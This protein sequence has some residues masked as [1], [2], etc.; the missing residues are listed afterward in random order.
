[1]VLGEKT[2]HRVSVFRCWYKDNGLKITFA[3]ASFEINQFL[4]WLNQILFFVNTCGLDN[5]NILR[6]SQSRN[7]G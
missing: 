2:L 1:M 5:F 4:N 6:K 7:A 3:P